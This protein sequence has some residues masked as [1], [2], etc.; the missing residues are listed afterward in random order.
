MIKISSH[1]IQDIHKRWINIKTIDIFYINDRDIMAV[2]SCNER[3]LI[4]IATFES[5]EKAQE[6]L[7]AIMDSLDYNANLD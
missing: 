4:C 7:D 2:P 1:F 6:I 5:K 3:N